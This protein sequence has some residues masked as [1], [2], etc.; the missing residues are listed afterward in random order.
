VVKETKTEDKMNPFIQA[1]AKE[2][3]EKINQSINIPFLNEEQEQMFFELV[4]TTV[5]QLTL[6]H[7]IP[8]MEKDNKEALQ[9]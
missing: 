5:F 1:L 3:A 6:G 2:L 8:L 7:L 4:V 9:R